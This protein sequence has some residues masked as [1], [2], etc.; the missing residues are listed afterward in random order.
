MELRLKEAMMDKSKTM[1]KLKVY[2]DTPSKNKKVP[3][4][5]S[6]SQKDVSSACMK[7][8]KASDK[9]ADSKL[10]MKVEKKIKR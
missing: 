5:K 10:G 6:S 1:A 9:Q 3:P 7:R 4:G 2:S 8:Q